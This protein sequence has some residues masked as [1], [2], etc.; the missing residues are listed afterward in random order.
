[1]YA[2]STP[3]NEEKKSHSAERDGRAGITIATRRYNIIIILRM[4]IIAQGGDVF[5]FCVHKNPYRDF[6]SFPFK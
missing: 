6:S 3:A 5:R 2:S 4:E 1:M